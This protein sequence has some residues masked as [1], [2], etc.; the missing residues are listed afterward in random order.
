MP[1]TPARA[2][3]RQSSLPG[4]PEFCPLALRT[5]TFACFTGQNL[6]KRVGHRGRRAVW[7]SLFLLL[8]GG[9]LPEL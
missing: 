2:L 7:P 8:E 5:E 1:E 4:T 6:P 9:R 3:P